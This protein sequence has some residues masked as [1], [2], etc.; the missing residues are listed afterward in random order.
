MEGG[1]YYKYMER[2][3][4]GES[5]IYLAAIADINPE[6]YKAAIIDRVNR[7][8]QIDKGTVLLSNLK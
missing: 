1:I 6:I 7:F 5:L 8:H 4:V 2:V 3:R